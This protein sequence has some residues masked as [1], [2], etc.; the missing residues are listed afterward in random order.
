M[1]RPRIKI[2]ALIACGIITQ[3]VQAQTTAPATAD[4]VSAITPKVDD[5]PELMLYKDMPVVVAAGKRVQTQRQ[6]PASVSV[7]TADDIDIFGYRSLAEVLRNQRSFYMYSDGLNWFGG[8]RG[9][10]RPSEWNARMMVQVDGRP[11]REVIFGQSH[12][13][14]DFVVPLEAVDHIEIVRGPG[15]ALYGSNAVFSV[16]DVVTK[17]GSD[18]NGAQVKLSGGTQDTGRANVLLGTTLKDGWDVLADFSGYTSQGDNHIRYDS[19]NDAAYNFGNIDHS[20]YEGVESGFVKARKGDFTLEL[21]LESRDKDNRTA[22]YLASWFNPG[23]MQEDRAN[24]TAR[25]DHD[26][27]DN[28]SIHAMVYYGYYRYSQSWMY[29]DDGSGNPYFY[30]SAA[31]DHWVG[32]ELHYDWQVTDQVHL[33]AGADATQSLYAQ[34]RDDDTIHGEVL[35]VKSAYRQWGL[36]A[37]GEYKATEWLSLTAGIRMDD[38]EGRGTSFSPRLAAVFTPTTKDTIK[39]LYGRAFRAP[40]LYELYYS[41]PGQNDPNPRLTPE[42]CDTYELVWEH[43]YHDGWRTSAGP[44][45][46][47]MAHAMQSVTDASGAAQTQNGGTAQAYGFEAEVQKKWDSGA[48]L[49]AYGTVTRAADQA[50]T[51][52]Q[53]PAWILGTAVAI[54]IINKRTFLALDPQIVGPQKSDLGD[55]VGPT[56][57]TNIVLTSRNVVKNLDLQAGLYNIFGNYA[58]LPHTSAA[59]Q[60]QPTEN[61]PHMQL[62]LS[63][64]YRF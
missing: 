58:R 47:E 32:E 40:N 49:R 13:D 10:M 2:Y 36:F 12:L 62:M 55:Y 33:L 53:S 57:I 29:D 27:A 7:V 64:T 20:D 19:I 56:F 38:I 15:S 61:Y 6:A 42:I 18:I 50:G 28:Q 31:V 43:Q 17:N 37:E 51:L 21:D 23:A 5:S 30:T 46:W 45:L 9:F 3:A 44:Y 35:N 52:A 4:N 11:T 48:R 41:S 25:F 1:R 8:T 22:R 54:P 34:Q 39:A 26:I 63:A 59:D 14:Q 24:M 16:I 60:V